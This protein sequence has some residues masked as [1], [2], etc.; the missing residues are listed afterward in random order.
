MP[1]KK[2]DFLHAG[3]NFADESWQ[4]PA[5]HMLHTEQVAGTVLMAVH[6][7]LPPGTR[8]SWRAE[9]LLAR[10]QGEDSPVPCQRG[11][12]QPRAVTAQSTCLGFSSV[13][14]F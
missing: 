9:M 11:P 8:V 6:S 4:F 14:N 1:R 13:P 3:K 7:V 10:Q 12:E 5:L 2:K